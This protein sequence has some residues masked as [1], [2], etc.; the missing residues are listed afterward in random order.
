ML[1]RQMIARGRYVGPYTL[2]WLVAGQRGEGDVIVGRDK[3]TDHIHE[4]S[5][6]NYGGFAGA[7]CECGAR[8]NESEI[9]HRLNATERLS[10]KR[11]KNIGRRGPRGELEI[12]HLMAY[13]VA[14]EDADLDK[15]PTQQKLTEEDMDVSS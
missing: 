1:A 10:A 2:E 8:L 9:D 5:S 11:A 6:G 15:L 13:A 14:L 4:W 3:V 7:E 12:P